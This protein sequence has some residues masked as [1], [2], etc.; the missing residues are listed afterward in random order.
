MCVLN[1][2]HREGLPGE[3][4]MSKHGLPG[5][6]KQ[7]RQ[8]T[9]CSNCKVRQDPGSRR[10]IRTIQDR[11]LNAF[12][13]GDCKVPGM[14]QQSETYSGRVINISRPIRSQKPLGYRGGSG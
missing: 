10:D 12:Q 2:R 14:A 1:K 7:V 8:R 13:G 9:R 6:G 3:E 4:V 5:K 11:R